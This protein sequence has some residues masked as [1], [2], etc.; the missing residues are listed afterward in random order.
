MKVVYFCLLIIVPTLWAA[1]PNP[2]REKNELAPEIAELVEKVDAKTATINTLTARFSQRKEVS[3]LKDTVVMNGK[4]SFKRKSGF[5]FDFDPKEDLLIIITAEETIS[6]SHKARKADRIKMKKRHG[7]LVERLLS[8]KLKSLSENFL[9]ETID[10]AEAGTH[11]LVLK[12]TKRRLKKRFTDIQLWINDTYMIHRIKVTSRDGDIYELSL[13]D[14]VLNGEVA[15]ELFHETIPDDY[16]M[17]DRMEFL[18][19]DGARL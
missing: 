10:G 13:E 15:D 1:E 17:S 16:E 9:I 14:V 2:G 3:L 12:P 19:G 11:H 8:D 4:F 6:L 7:R 18:F 5:R